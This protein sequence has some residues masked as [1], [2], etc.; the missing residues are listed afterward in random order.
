MWLSGLDTVSL[1][2]CLTISSTL[3]VT[4]RIIG[5]KFSGIVSSTGEKVIYDTPGVPLGG[6]SSKRAKV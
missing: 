6:F 5:M 4:V 1:C 2:L 3:F